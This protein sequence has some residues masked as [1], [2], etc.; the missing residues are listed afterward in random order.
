LTGVR[1]NYGNLKYLYTKIKVLVV[2][3]LNLICFQI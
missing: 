1:K 3:I 2:K